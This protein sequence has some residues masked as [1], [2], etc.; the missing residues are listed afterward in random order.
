MVRGHLPILRV[1]KTAVLVEMVRKILLKVIAMGV[2]V[3][4][5]GRKIEGSFEHSKDSWGQR[6][7][8]GVSGTTVSERS[9]QGQREPC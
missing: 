3:M 2:K 7:E 6:A 5:V 9:D 8:R 1:R 4:S